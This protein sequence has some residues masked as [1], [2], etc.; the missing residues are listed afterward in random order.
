M[1]L[2]ILRFPAKRTLMEASRGRGGR[3]MRALIPKSARKADVEAGDV[4]RGEVARHRP[5]LHP[6]KTFNTDDHYLNGVIANHVLAQ[7]QLVA[8]GRPFCLQQDGDSSHNVKE[9]AAGFDVALG[10]HRYEL[11]GLRDLV[12]NPGKVAGDSATA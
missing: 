1:S 7:I 4:T 9:K 10:G 3:N 6:E 2:E 11:P 5:T 8:R 12:G